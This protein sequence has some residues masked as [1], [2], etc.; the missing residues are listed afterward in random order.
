MGAEL[1]SNLRWNQV[2]QK[3]ILFALLRFEKTEIHP[4]YIS[5]E[6][7]QQQKTKNLQKC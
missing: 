5:L 4:N 1:V 6:K 7:L 2:V 3:E